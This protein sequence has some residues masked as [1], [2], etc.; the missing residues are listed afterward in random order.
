MNCRE[1]ETL[2]FAARDGALDD[3]RRAA[4]ALHVAQCPA[5]REVQAELE[6]AATAWR[7][8]DHAAGVPAVEAEWH[9]IRRRIRGGTA[10]PET[11]TGAW[12]LPSWLGIAATLAVVAFAAVFGTRWFRTDVADPLADP[13]YVS[14][15]V[16]HNTSDTTMVYDDAESGWLV[17]WVA[18][19][20]ETSGS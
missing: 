7:A 11:A 13:G 20:G 8:A 19:E 18:N 12:R 5:C 3:T 15:V 9:A 16:V 6:N 2:I 1:A 17:V 14:Y 10:S 4:L